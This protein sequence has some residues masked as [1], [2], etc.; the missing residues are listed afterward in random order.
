MPTLI[1]DPGVPAFPIIIQT[2][3]GAN[4]DLELT[5]N[6]AAV[7]ES[8]GLFVKHQRITTS[9]PVVVPISIVAPDTGWQVTAAHEL[10]SRAQCSWETDGSQCNHTWAETERQYA[11]VVTA[12]H[13]S[14]GQKKRTVYLKVRPEPDLPEL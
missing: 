13:P 12:S 2:S 1:S 6:G 9:D 5:A 8:E 3:L 10:D 14:S 4:G 7:P 11:V